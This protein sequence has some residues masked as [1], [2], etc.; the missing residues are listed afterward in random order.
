MNEYVPIIV[1]VIAGLF[2]LWSVIFTW[3]LKQSS[4][5]KNRNLG[6]EEAAYNDLK[7]LYIKIHQSF[8]DLIKETRSYGKSDLNARFSALTAEMRLLASPEA[9]AKYHQV[10][11]L[12]QEWAPLYCRAYP[13]SKNGIM[14][15]Q[16]PDPTLK[17]KEPEKVA[18]DRFY[19]KYQ[20]FINHLRSEIAV[21]T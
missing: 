10:S 7:S 4:D 3:Q 14:I 12:Y 20:D 6:K 18:Y 5:K 13:P 11:E 15:I 17:Y 19:E 21:N 8:E 16:S 9:I 1:S 2:A